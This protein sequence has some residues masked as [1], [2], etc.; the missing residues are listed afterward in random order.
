V[1]DLAS[2]HVARIEA[3]GFSE[4]PWHYESAPKLELQTSPAK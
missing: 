4:N 1:I 3:S 2:D